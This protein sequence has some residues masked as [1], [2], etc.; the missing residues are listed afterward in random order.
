MIHHTHK[1]PNFSKRKMPI[2]SIIL[3]HT[4]GKSPGCIIWLCDPESRVSAHYVVTREGS[5]YE[6]VPVN[7]KAWHAGRGAFDL[8]KDGEISYDETRWNDRSIGIELEA[9]APDYEYPEHQMKNLDWLVKYLCVKHSID[10]SR[11]LGHKE[12]APGR[13]IDPANF[14]MGLYRINIGQMLGL[15]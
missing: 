11:I 3:H 8:N 13:K 7:K 4:G 9:F 10:P 5:I 2:D 15:E 6:L 12:I 1:S 14:N